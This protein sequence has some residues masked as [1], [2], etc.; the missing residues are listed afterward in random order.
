VCVELRAAVWSTQASQVGR[1]SFVEM[2]S[3]PSQGDPQTMLKEE[4]AG[5]RLYKVGENQFRIR[6]SLSAMPQ[7]RRSE[8]A[9]Q[10]RDRTCGSFGRTGRT[11]KISYCNPTCVN[12]YPVLPVSADR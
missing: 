5:V 3:A 11:A 6:G 4:K 7:I 9:L 2:G 12:L 10:G 1:T 8:P